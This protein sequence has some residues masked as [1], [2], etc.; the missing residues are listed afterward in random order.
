MFA[1]IFACRCA[2]FRVSC[3]L[4]GHPLH[5]ADRF[6]NLLD[7]ALLLL[8]AQAHFLYKAAH[9]LYKYIH[10]LASLGNFVQLVFAAI[11]TLDG[12]LNQL[13]CILGGLRRTLRKITHFVCDNRE[14]HS[15][16]TGW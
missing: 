16:F 15:R 6:G 9:C 1:E 4:L 5:L 12:I 2:F 13:R 7:P 10:A 14:A 3:D 8:T 11:G